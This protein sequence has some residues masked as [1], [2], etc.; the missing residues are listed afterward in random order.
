LNS[1]RIHQIAELVGPL[2]DDRKATLQ[3]VPKGVHLLRALVTRLADDQ[4][5]S[6]LNRGL[7]LQH[8]LRN[9]QLE[10]VQRQF[11]QKLT[12]SLPSPVIELA[13]NRLHQSS[14]NVV[15]LLQSFRTDNFTNSN[16]ADYACSASVLQKLLIFAPSTAYHGNATDDRSAAESMHREHLRSLDAVQRALC[17]LSESGNL[18]SLLELVQRGIRTD[19]VLQWITQLVTHL[20]LPKLQVRLEHVHEL[21]DILERHAFSDWIET[22]S[23]A[24]LNV[25]SAH[26][27]RHILTQFRQSGGG[28]ALAVL[29]LSEERTL[30]TIEDL[31]A[32]LQDSS[33]SIGPSSRWLRDASLPIRR[34]VSAVRY[35]KQAGL[36]DV[37][38]ESRQ[39]STDAKKV[40]ETNEKPAYYAF[41]TDQLDELMHHSEWLRVWLQFQLE[42]DSNTVDQVLACPLDLGRL[43]S[44]DKP[45]LPLLCDRATLQDVLNLCPDPV[46]PLAAH[47][48]CTLS[49]THERL[50][51][52]FVLKTLAV[53]KI[54]DNVSHFF[55]FFS[56]ILIAV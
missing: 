52:E 42:L 13:F 55:A 18:Q 45:V 56:L 8:I 7:P 46:R 48:I 2:I 37:Q 27:L 11:R 22:L 4:V 40:K 9:E 31:F 19:R 51:S 6:H 49:V 44:L 12:G 23:A 41:E 5:Q 25:S 10:H 39:E 21:T 54:A 16:N 35:F 28:F 33:L 29:R 17:Q 24:N 26:E 36:F 20:R 15:H 14:L 38:C 53:R 30:S 1:N 50:M 3:H 43:L 47:A 32:R 34:A